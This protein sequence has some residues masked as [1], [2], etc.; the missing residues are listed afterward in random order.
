MLKLKLCYF[1]HLMW[2]TGSLENTL[3][4]GKIESRRRS[5]LQKMS[6]LDGITDS[7][8][9]SLSKL[10]ELVL[11]R[12][13]WHAAVH[14]SRKESDTTERLNWT[15]AHFKQVSITCVQKCFWSFR[16]IMLVDKMCILLESFFFFILVTEAWYNNTV[17]C[18]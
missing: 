13:A 11:E 12:E 1:S 16:E 14:G 18:F 2:R 4:L 8:D 9:M 5:R 10:Q 3:M 6:W 7:M 15:E 17:F